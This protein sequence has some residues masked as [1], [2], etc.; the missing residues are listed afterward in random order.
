MDVLADA[1]DILGELGVHFETSAQRSDRRRD[2][3]RLG[4][5]SDPRRGDLEVDRRHQRRLRCALQSRLRRRHRRRADHRRRGLR[6]RLL[7]HAGAQ[8]R[9][10]DEI[11]DLAARSRAPTSNRIVKAVEDGFE[12]SEASNTPVMLEVRIRCL[13][14]PRPLHRQGQQAPRLHAGA[15]AGKSA[16]RHQPHRAAAGLLPAREGKDRAA[17]AGGGRSS[18]GSASSTSSSTAMSTMSASSCRAACTMA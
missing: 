11:A 9:L 13:P 15:G 12:L 3:G 16:P 8:P 18:S 5:V 10:C 14:C 4:D 2:A 7:H 6:R 1:Q 17:L